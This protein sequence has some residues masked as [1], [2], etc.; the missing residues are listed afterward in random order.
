[1]YKFHKRSLLPCTADWLFDW[2]CRP[3]A[4]MDLQPPA[5]SI[6][7]LS[8]AQPLH[9]GQIV[10]F[11]MFAG[12]IPIIWESQ[13]TEVQPG[14]SFTDTQLKGPFRHWQHV[15]GFHDAGNGECL[16]DDSIEY[17]LPFDGVAGNIMAKI[18]ANRLNGMF[19]FRHAKLLD[20]ASS[21]FGREDN[22]L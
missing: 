1:M 22:V 15:H 12:P 19:Q 8:E 14:M 10:R 16:M 21:R 2:H 4:F 18:V 17:S 3:T 20:L 11:R 6:R 5:S 9:E 7:L 13:I